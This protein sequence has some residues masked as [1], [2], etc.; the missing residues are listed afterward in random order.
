MSVSVVTPTTPLNVA[1]T[2][3]SVNW[4][5]NEDCTMTGMMHRTPA[6][7]RTGRVAMDVRGHPGPITC[8]APSSRFVVGAY[9]S[10]TA[11]RIA[12]ADSLVSFVNFRF[13]LFRLLFQA[14]GCW[15][16]T[17]VELLVGTV[18][19][20]DDVDDDHLRERPTPI[21]LRPP[22]RPLAPRLKV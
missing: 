2:V 11:S 5:A 12:P 22:H 1:S 17:P 8:S 3:P 18:E 13:L 10:G 4:P 7:L 15:H 14:E 19:L 20:G 21:A 6:A 9:T 16:A